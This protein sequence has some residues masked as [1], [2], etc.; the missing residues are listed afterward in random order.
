C[1]SGRWRWAGVWIGLAALAK[2][3]FL[4]VSPVLGWYLLRRKGTLRATGA[5]AIAVGTIAIGYAPFWFDGLLDHVRT[6]M[7]LYG[8]YFIFNSPLYDVIRTML[9]Y[10]EGVTPDVASTVVPIFASI[11]LVL[12][13]TAALWVNGKEARLPFGLALAAVVPLLLTSVFH[14]WYLLL[15]IAFGALYLSPAIAVLSLGA[16]L[17][18][19]AY[20]AASGQVP[21]WVLAVEFSTFFVIAIIELGKV[22]I[23][24]VLERRAARKFR[25]LKPYLTPGAKVLDVGSGEGFVGA[26]IAAEGH[27]VQLLDVDDRNQTGLPHCRYDGET[28]PYQ[29]DSFDVAV[30]AYV[31]H[32][33]RDPERVLAEVGRVAKRLIVFESV[34]ETQRDLKL[35]TFLDHLANR[36]R[37]MKPE[38]LHFAPAEVWRGRLEGLGHDVVAADQLGERVHKHWLFVSDRSATAEGSATLAMP[39]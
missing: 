1:V 29:D 2:L 3:T 39:K 14:P 32:H 17:T 35:L 13:G 16:L 11:Q 18:Y 28:I 10:V 26:C 8:G 6:S 23:G 12:I 19:T 9:G 27:S 24:W 30:V 22:G 38:P 36:L 37:G 31:L 5:A 7:A 34:F 15:A 21:R 20:A 25:A 33:C 4:A